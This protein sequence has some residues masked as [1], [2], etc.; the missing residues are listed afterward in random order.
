MVAASAATYDEI[1]SLG[2]DVFWLESVPEEAGRVTICRNG[3]PLLPK[4]FSARSRVHE[5]GGGS[6]IACQAGI[7]FVNFRDQELYQVEHRPYALT[8]TG[9]SERYADLCHPEG[10]DYLIAVCE[11]HA[12]TEPGE[13]EHV[14]NRLVTISLTDGSIS[15]LHQG[16]DFYA[17]PR[18]CGNRLAFVAWD[19]PNMPWQTTLLY[20]AELNPSTKALDSAHIIAGGEGESV[21]EPHWGETRLFFLNDADGW[22]NLCCHD[23]AGTRYLHQCEAEF[24]GPQ[25]MFHSHSYAVITDELL[26]ARRSCRGEESLVM[27][28]GTGRLSDWHEQAGSYDH[29]HWHAAGERLLCVTGAPERGERIEEF[30]ITRR[31][32]RAGGDTTS[33]RGEECNS[34]NSSGRA[35]LPLAGGANSATITASKRPS[36]VPLAGRAH[37]TLPDGCISIPQA[38]EFA[39]DGGPAYAYFYAPTNPEHEADAGE[40]PPLLVTTHGGPTTCA[41]QRQNLRIQ[42][43]TSR[44]WAVADLNYAGSTGF[45]TA[46]RRKLDGR[47]GVSDVRDCEAL[48]SCLAERKLIDANRAAIRG[49]SAGGYTTLAA[50]TFSD[51]FRAGASAYG[52][53]DLEALAKDTHK[54]ESE[55]LDSL[56]GPWPEQSDIYK[57]RSP[58]YSSDRL[59]C[60]IIFFQGGRDV[61]VPPD[62]SQRMVD[63]LDAKGIP[64]AYILYPEEGHGFRDAATIAHCLESEF[65]FFCR[66]FGINPADKLPHLDIKHL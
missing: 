55:Y 66:V 45:G 43:Y 1:Q 4:G 65:A 27:I 36:P 44:G 64:H 22:W 38:I 37:Q 41:R 11:T 15:T 46:Y 28:D 21:M 53:S 7:Y 30:A 61:I 47:W 23:A 49:G 34:S 54:F 24:G 40:L 31:A 59:A 8:D 33:G 42:Y 51:V 29:L 5:Y 57:A 63:A 48:V 20:L 39:S 14:L 9:S 13:C 2:E 26:V 10:A 62:Q 35:S 25:W 52:V 60:P 3:E 19:H 6:Y 32:S 18:M 58:L 56:V 16:H 12:A 50:L 17:S